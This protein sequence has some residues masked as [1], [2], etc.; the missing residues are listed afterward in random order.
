MSETVEALAKALEKKNFKLKDKVTIGHDEIVG[1]RV[2]ISVE[3]RYNDFERKDKENIDKF[4]KKELPLQEVIFTTD[5][6]VKLKYKRL[7]RWKWALEA[8]GMGSEMLYLT[9]IKWISELH[10]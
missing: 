6:N 9:R 4:Y 8:I 5:K 7:E 3:I 1:S 2:N 10:I